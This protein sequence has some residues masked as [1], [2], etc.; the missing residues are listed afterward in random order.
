MFNSDN[1]AWV[2]LGIDEIPSLRIN[3]NVLKNTN[4]N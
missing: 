3:F 1:W 2:E 4:K